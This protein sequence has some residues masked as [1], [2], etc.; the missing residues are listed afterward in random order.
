MILNVSQWWSGRKLCITTL[1]IGTVGFHANQ[2]KL[3]NQYSVLSHIY[4]LK[5]MVFMTL[6]V[7]Q[8]RS[9]RKLSITTLSICT[10]G[11]LDNE[12]E[13]AHHKCVLS[14]IYV[15]KSVVFLTIR[16]SHWWSGRK[17]I[18]TTL[19]ICTVDFLANEF[20]LANQYNVLSHI[21][22]I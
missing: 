5:T 22:H 15:S 10:V 4:G 1:S 9:G 12:F 11:F 14:Q 21:S 18:A 2:Y 8:W 20:Y 13:L 17:C 16:N 6:R 19:S 7:S 3:C